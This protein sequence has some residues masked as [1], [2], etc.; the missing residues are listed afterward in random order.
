MS[1]LSQFLGSSSGATLWVS[2]TTYPVGKQVISPADLQAY[3]RKTA[4][5]G[6]TD[7]STDPTNWVPFGA[8]A[9]K[10]IQRGLINVFSGS[11][12]N[13]AIATIA[14]VNT[15]KT[16][17]RLCGFWSNSINAQDNPIL[18]LVNPT[19]IRATRFTN[20]N[21]MQTMVSWELTEF[22]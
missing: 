21:T 16:E 2:G 4:G 3:I 15:A 14:T 22:Y 7:P 8:R 13:N 18:E 1:A 17:L 20:N 12:T 10:S 5:A 6:V 11:G 9:I 19:T